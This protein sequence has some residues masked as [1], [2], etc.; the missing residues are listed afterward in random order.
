MQSLQINTT[1]TVHFCQYTPRVKKQAIIVLSIT[2]QFFNNCF[3]VAEFYMTACFSQV[4]SMAIFGT[5]IFH[6]VV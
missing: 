1:Q 4:L 5:L 3:W 2:C 6:K